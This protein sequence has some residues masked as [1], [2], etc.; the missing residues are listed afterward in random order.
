MSYVT[1]AGYWLRHSRIFATPSN[2]SADWGNSSTA[3]S[4]YISC[5]PTGSSAEF[6][7]FRSSILLTVSASIPPG[8]QARGNRWGPSPSRE[9]T[10]VTARR[11]FRAHGSGAARQI[12][13]GLDR[14]E[15]PGS[16][17]TFEFVFAA[18]LEFDAGS[19]DEVDDRSRYEHLARPRDGRDAL[20][21]MDA[22]A[23]D[24]N[25]SQLDFTGVNPGSDLQPQRQQRGAKRAGAADGASGTVESGKHP[26]T[27]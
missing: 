18:V 25:A 8:W 16:G 27:R 6:P 14:E 10:V 7:R 15:A 2:R 24:F 4:A 22:D 21:D 23:C 13:S 5:A 19:G 1:D 11:A 3:S 26:V 17:D 12:R 20:A 9:Q